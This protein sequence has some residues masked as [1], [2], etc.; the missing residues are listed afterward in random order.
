MATSGDDRFVLPKEPEMQKYSSP[1]QEIIQTN[2]KCNPKSSSVILLIQS[3][4]LVTV[5]IS[6]EKQN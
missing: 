3:R 5:R 6:D 4:F 1:E 2:C